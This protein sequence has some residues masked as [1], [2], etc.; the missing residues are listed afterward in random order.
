MRAPADFAFKLPEALD[1][2]SA[3]PLLCAGVTV[4][5]P[6]KRHITFPGMKVGV[7]GIGGLGHMAVQIA[8]K[9]GAEVTP[10]ARLLT[11]RS[12]APPDLAFVH[13]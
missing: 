9:L 7:L 5:A 12:V 4:Y 6:L 10:C 3:A 8:A 2:A 11:T 1:S 13:C